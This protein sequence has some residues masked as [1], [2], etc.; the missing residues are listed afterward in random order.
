MCLT[1]GK[2]ELRVVE[3]QNDDT[4]VE[5]FV[6]TAKGLFKTVQAFYQA[7]Y[8]ITTTKSFKRFHEY[9]SFQVAIKKSINVSQFHVLIGKTFSGG[10]IFDVLAA[11][12]N[13]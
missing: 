7:T 4:F 3:N 12:L 9:G 1:K 2:N 10:Q 13:V 5:F 11:G 6:P 8:L